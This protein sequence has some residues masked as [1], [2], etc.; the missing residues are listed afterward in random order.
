[1]QPV[2]PT[3]GPQRNPRAAVGVVLGNAHDA[4]A[5]Q[6]TRSVGDVVGGGEAEGVEV[7]KWASIYGQDFRSLDSFS[8]LSNRLL[9][10]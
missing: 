3:P 6:G 9:G 4:R 10:R 5:G 1:M 7:C 2:D 8:G